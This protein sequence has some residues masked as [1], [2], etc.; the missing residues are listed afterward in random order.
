MNEDE[1]SLMD[2]SQGDQFAD[3]DFGD[4]EGWDEEG[5]E[6]DATADDEIAGPS[7]KKKSK[8]N[9][10]IILGGVVVAVAVLYFQM[11]GA[12]P[13]PQAPPPAMEQQASTAV[14]QPADTAIPPPP[15]PLPGGQAQAPVQNSG[16]QFT[17][18]F[19]KNPE[20]FQQV[21]KIRENMQFED[22]VTQDENVVPVQPQLPPVSPTVQEPLTPLPS[23]VAATPLAAV[24][25]ASL[26]APTPGMEKMDARLS[27]LSAR[28]DQLEA[29]VE[30]LAVPAANPQEMASLRSAI[31]RLSDKVDSMAAKPA[32]VSRS[33]VAA[34][35]ST[36]K[37]KSTSSVS[38]VLKSA[39]PGRAIV[40]RAGQSEVYSVGVGDSLEGI[41]RI[42]S[43]A[44]E[45][46]RWIVRGT[47]GSVSQ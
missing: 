8:S 14:P 2:E 18:G 4:D 38:W 41:G 33:S 26:Q 24:P 3:E 1:K 25:A 28:L 11:G 39:Q 34:A 13:A 22:Y 6:S 7:P 10:I 21:E 12:P 29:A 40:S 20:A 15:P 45:N 30:A 5:Y 43:V 16:D 32:P 44:L 9:L 27:D 19:L 17:G 31:D 46:G 42:D 47:K 35:P 23:E 37:K 36:P